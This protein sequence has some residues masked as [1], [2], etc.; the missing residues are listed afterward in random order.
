MARRSQAAGRRSQAAGRSADDESL[1]IAARSLR[2]NDE[3]LSDGCVLQYTY[4]LRQMTATGNR[5]RG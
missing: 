5:V 3:C 2:G 4:L 1:D